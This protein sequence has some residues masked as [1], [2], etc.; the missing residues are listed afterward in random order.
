[1][2]PESPACQS[3]LFASGLQ[4]QHDKRE[5]CNDST[6]GTLLSQNQLCS[7]QTPKNWDPWDRESPECRNEEQG[8]LSD[9]SSYQPLCDTL[10]ILQ[11]HCHSTEHRHLGVW[12]SRAVQYPP[13]PSRHPCWQHV[14]HTVPHHINTTWAELLP[15]NTLKKYLKRNRYTKGSSSSSSAP[16]CSRHHGL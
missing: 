15:Q 16:S 12:R 2:T 9:R 4:G 11:T 5:G 7:N 3:L 1:M 6:L 13:D 10:E 8:V 14:S